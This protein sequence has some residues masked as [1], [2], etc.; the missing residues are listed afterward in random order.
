VEGSNPAVGGVSLPTLELF[1]IS[2]PS[3]NT[4]EFEADAP[5][6]WTTSTVGDIIEIHYYHTGQ[7]GG[8]G[9]GVVSVTLTANMITGIDPVPLVTP[10]LADSND[11]N[12]HAVYKRGASSGSQSNIVAFPIDTKPPLILTSTSNYNASPQVIRATPETGPLVLGETINLQGS[13][14]LAFTSPVNASPYTVT[15][16]DVTAGFANINIVPTSTNSW[17]YHANRGGVSQ[18]G[19]TF[20]KY[21]ALNTVAKQADVPVYRNRIERACCWTNNAHHRDDTR[22]WFSR[23]RQ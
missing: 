14:S 1:I 12:A 17:H 23:C 10:V 3:D 21:F 9:S 15:A 6:T 19:A 5:V 20:T 2:A 4:A 16:G 22:I 11:W 13:I 7:Q 18:F 8:A